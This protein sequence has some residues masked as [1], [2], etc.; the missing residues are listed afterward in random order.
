MLLTESELRKV[1]RKLI[2]LEGDPLE[3]PTGKPSKRP[4]DDDD[5]LSGPTNKPES[6]PED[7]IESRLDAV[8]DTVSKILKTLKEK[9]K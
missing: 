9:M 6:A 1:I 2:L 7:D 4:S 3:G 5:P 8:E